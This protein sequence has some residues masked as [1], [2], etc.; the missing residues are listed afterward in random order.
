VRRAENLATFIVL[1]KSES[2]NLL[3][4]SG[5]V[6]ACNGIALPLPVWY[7]FPYIFLPVAFL[8]GPFQKCQKLLTLFSWGKNN[9]VVYVWLQLGRVSMMR[10][11]QLLLKQKEMWKE[12]QAVMIIFQVIIFVKRHFLL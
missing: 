7:A 8:F 6:K 12:N 4:P 1:K 2:L 5:P 9:S 10:V 3:E 11:K